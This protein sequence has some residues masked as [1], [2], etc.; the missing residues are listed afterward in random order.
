MLNLLISLILCVATTILLQ[1]VAGLNIWYSTIIA[2]VVFTLCYFLL[3]RFIMKRIAGLM[4]QAQR[5]LQA[6]R[7]EKAVK[8]L[9]DGY[10]YAPWQFYIKPQINAQIGTI[11][12]LK[13]DFAKAFEYLEKGFVRHWVAMSMLAICHMKKNRTTK[14]VE[15]FE[16]ATSANKK[17]P[18]VWNL[19]AYCLERIGERDKAIAVM[20]KGIKK[21]GGD[22]TLAAN[23]ELLKAGK[24]M[25][26]RAYGDMWYQFHLEKP[27]AV[28]KQQTKAFTG[29]RKI[30]RR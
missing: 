14:M 21:T 26:M 24:R 13:R 30:V 17:E 15:T 29:R 12:Y 6:N 7:S 16:K 25:K 19:Y 22:E 2:L 11:H 9:E 27:G 23:L 4:E 28:T 3:T 5:E 18:L 1:T 20:E 10:K 8:T